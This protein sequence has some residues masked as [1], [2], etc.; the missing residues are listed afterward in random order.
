MEHPICKITTSYEKQKEVL[1]SLDIVNSRI[2][3]TRES[4]PYWIQWAF[5]PHHCHGCSERGLILGENQPE[6][7]QR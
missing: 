6:K 2:P 4:E 5:Q 7:V 1:S 3:K